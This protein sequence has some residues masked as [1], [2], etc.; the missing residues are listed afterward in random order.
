MRTSFYRYECSK[1]GQLFLVVVTDNPDTDKCLPQEMQANM[2]KYTGVKKQ[3]AHCY[4][5]GNLVGRDDEIMALR[6][7]GHTDEEIKKTK[8]F[9]S[10]LDKMRVADAACTEMEA[11]IAKDSAP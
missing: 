11:T 7:C 5:N 3:C 9:W 8:C 1:C 4:H 2:V 10:W 6:F